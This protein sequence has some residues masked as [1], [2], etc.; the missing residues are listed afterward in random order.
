MALCLATQEAVCL[1]QIM[2]NLKFIQQSSIIIHEDNQACIEFSNHN[3]H[4]AKSKHIQP[5]YQYT[6]EVIKKGDIK[7][8]Y[9]PPSEN[10]ADNMTKPLTPHNYFPH[11]HRLLVLLP[12]IGDPEIDKV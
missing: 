5:R 4:H 11:F 1:F 10:P 9:I 2:K 6:R 12:L 8:A 3:V 7:L